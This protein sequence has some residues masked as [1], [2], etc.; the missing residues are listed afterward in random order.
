MD[1]DYVNPSSHFA[2]FNRRTF[3]GILFIGLISALITVL[4]A[5]LLD[6]FVI[7]PALCGST[8]ESVCSNS[9]SISFHVGSLIAA[10]VSVAMFVNLSV[11]R[12]LLV[13]LAAIIGSWGMYNLSFFLIDTPWYLQAGI[14]FAVNSVAFLTFAW[15]LRAY[16]LAVGVILT[17]LITAAMIVAI[18][19]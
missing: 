19:F 2:E 11:Y 13:V 7:T 17:I 10:V 8:N 12:P 1:S 14:I 9:T 6:Q 18:N 3:F 15:M 5:R 4:A 16:N